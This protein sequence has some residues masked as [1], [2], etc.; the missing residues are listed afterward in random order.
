VRYFRSVRGRRLFYAPALATALRAEVAGFDLVHTHAIYLWPLGAASRAARR[1]GVPHVLSPRGMLEKDLIERKTG[2]WKSLLIAF[3]ERSRLETAAGIHVTSRREHE[4]ALA[5]G[6]DFAPFYE[7]PNGVEVPPQPARAPE[8]FVLFVGRL[9]WKKGLDRLVAA[10]ALAPSATLVIAGPDDEG[11]GATV[12]RLASANGTSSRIRFAGPAD[13]A[14]KRDW[15]RRASALVLP[16]YSENFGNVVIEAWA[17]ACPVIVTREVGLADAVQQSGGGW[18]VEPG[19]STLGQAIEHAVTDSSA[20]AQA[21]M[22]GRAE[23][24]RRFTW[25]MVAEQMER[26]YET[27]RHSARHPA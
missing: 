18:V 24:C 9:N 2:F 11:Y 19:P 10:M 4:Q 20:R 12:S 15:L 13:A 14:A 17:E 23:A 7:V 1:A 22:L 6:F 26:V 25:P 16:S 5:F 8:P 3:V 27:V 21:G